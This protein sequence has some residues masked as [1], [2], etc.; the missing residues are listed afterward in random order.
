MKKSILLI[1]TTMMTLFFATS[2]L[3]GVMSL[4][5]N[6]D[7]EGLSKTPAKKKVESVEGGIARNFKQQP[8]LIPH[9]I[10]KY[11]INLKH[12]GCLKCHSPKTYKREKAPKVGD[13]HFK[14]RN[15]KILKTVARRRYFCIQCHA[16]QVAAQ[17]LVQNTFKKAE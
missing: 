13:S 16:P 8:P 4:R 17:P 2:T 1:T 7:I 15:G 6:S 9:K 12:N 11:R 3:S 5:G 10:D 14:D